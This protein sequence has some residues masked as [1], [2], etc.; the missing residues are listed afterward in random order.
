MKRLLSKYV[1]NLYLIDEYRTSKISNMNYQMYGDET[2]EE[3]YKCKNHTLELTSICKSKNEQNVINKQMH[4]IL[5]FKT[6]KKSIQCY[7][8][9]HNG[10]KKENAN[11]TILRLIQRDKNAVLNFRTITE[12]ILNGI[13]IPLA[14]RRNFNNGRR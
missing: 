4:G 1:K 7:Y 13:E 6:N 5:T 14:F 3:Y 2:K 11:G 8:L 9:L 10:S 12:C